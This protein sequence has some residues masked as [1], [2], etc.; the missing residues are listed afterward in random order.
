MKMKIKRLKMNSKSVRQRK[1]KSRVK[2]D[3]SMRKG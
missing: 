2:K 3:E 1:G